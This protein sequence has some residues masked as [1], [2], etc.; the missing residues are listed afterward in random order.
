MTGGL[1]PLSGGGG[2]CNAMQTTSLEVLATLSLD[3]VANAETAA[4]I[5]SNN[6]AKPITNDFF[7]FTHF[8]S[9]LN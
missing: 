1:I 2:Q 4:T 7:I 9:K 8:L 5:M 3:D 6:R